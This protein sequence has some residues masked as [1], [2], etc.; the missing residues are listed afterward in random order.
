MIAAR[1]FIQVVSR[2]MAFAV[3]VHALVGCNAQLST[4]TETGIPE[5]AQLNPEIQLDPS[6]T[7][8]VSQLPRFMEYMLPEYPRLAKQAGLEGRVW[9]S[10]L[11]DTHG[12][13][14]EVQIHQTSGVQTLDDAAVAS[15]KQ[16][17]FSP[18]RSNGEKVAV[19]IIYAVDFVLE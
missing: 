5:G 6:E 19:R 9:V 11:V 15:A 4:S 18:A 17:R 8:S 14:R 12:L 2:I 13:A 1:R 10:L 3:L 16:C 7:K